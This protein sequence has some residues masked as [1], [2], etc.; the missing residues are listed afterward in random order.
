MTSEQF[1]AQV[2]NPA[3]LGELKQLLGLPDLVKALHQVE[4]TLCHMDR[5]IGLLSEAIDR[6]TLAQARTDQMVQRLSE[7]QAR[8]D[9]TVERLDQKVERLNEKVERLNEKVER[10][11]QKVEGLIEAQ[12]RTDQTIKVLIEAQTRT[13]RT[14]DRLGQNVAEFR[15]AQIRTETTLERFMVSSEKSTAALRKEV[16]AL[17]ATVGLD[18]EDIVSADLPD[19]LHRHHQIH[20]NLQCPCFLSELGDEELDA[21]GEGDGPNGKITI[22][23]EAKNRVRTREVDAFWSKAERVRALVNG[24]FFPVLIGRA[25]YPDAKQ[26]AEELG[27]TLV[28]TGLLRR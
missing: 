28:S 4:A 23:A 16:G 22:L 14:V 15:D 18:V 5:R 10:L 24:A 7:A 12:T 3:V 21:F 11:D 13:D 27:L 26:R 1:L 25:I 8:T 19:W 9:L 17:A 2:R 20:A 6:L